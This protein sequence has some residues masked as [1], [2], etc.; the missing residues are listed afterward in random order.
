MIKNLKFNHFGLA[1]KNKKK[2]EVF[3]LN[4]GYKK[5][6]EVI[7]NN[8]KVRAMIMTHPVN[9]DIEII[10]KIR[11]SDVTPIDRLISINSSVIYHICFEC[12]DIKKLEIEMKKKNLLFKK[13]VKRT[14]SPLFNKDVSFYFSDSMGIIEIIHL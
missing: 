3:L 4:L 1:V 5:K 10:S 14:F 8:Q 7:D 6:K 2:S 12:A 11:Q 13:I 9:F